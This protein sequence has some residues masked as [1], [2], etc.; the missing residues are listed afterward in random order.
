MAI[1]LPKPLRPRTGRGRMLLWACLAALIFGAINAGEPLNDF[2][3]DLRATTHER[4]AS[5]DI[6]LVAIDDPTLKELGTFPLPRRYYAKMLDNLRQ[7]GARRVFFDLTFREKSNPEDDAQ[8][9]A[10]LR[11][12]GSNA[13]LPILTAP[14]S[15]TGDQTE[16]FP[17][18]Q[19]SERAQLAHININ[20]GYSG[21]VRRL[22]FQM[23]LGDENYPSFAAKLAGVEAG[24]GQFL[25]D[26]SIDLKTIPRLSGLDVIQ[27]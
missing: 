14:D 20:Y 19:F 8:F 11:R 6:V 7:L 25:V 3:T 5:G 2:L 12:M 23:R 9:E 24:K 13:V 1:L 16:N 4:P 10:A 26:Y 17:L 22:P 21:E 15:I 27:G 18:A